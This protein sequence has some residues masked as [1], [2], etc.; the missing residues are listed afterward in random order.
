[1]KPKRPVFLDLWRI[2]LP[3]MGMAS[4]LHRVSG[5]LMVLTIPL[6]AH[7][8]HQSLESPEGFAATAATLSAWPMR[9]VVL[10]LAWALLHHLFAGIRYL[11]LDFNIGLE[12]EAARRSAQ[13][14]IGGAVAALVLGVLL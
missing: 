12:R 7:L 5:T 14:V 11:A 13:V 3:A 1:M 2:K 8:L 9:L 6:G 10:G 4:I